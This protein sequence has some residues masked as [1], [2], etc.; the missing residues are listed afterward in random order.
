MEPVTEAEVVAAQK[1][2]AE[3][4]VAIGAAIPKGREVVRATAEK[5]IQ[6]CY[7]FG[8]GQVLFKPTKARLKQFRC[9]T[10]AA[11]S[12]FVGGDAEFGEDAGFALRPWKKVRFENVG[13]K[14]GRGIALAMGDYFFTDEHGTE[15]MVEYS[16]GY[17]RCPDGKVRI[18]L[19]HSSLPYAPSQVAL[20]DS[21]AA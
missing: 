6:D 14:A 19:H 4:I 18:V 16:F 21:S 17:H 3:G 10:R 5:F 20:A 7:A 1:A 12:Y 11:L 9:E 15:V 2:W 8:A 13:I